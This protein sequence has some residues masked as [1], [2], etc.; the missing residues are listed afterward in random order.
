MRLETVAESFATYRAAV[1]PREASAVQVDE[2]RRAFYAGTYFCLMNLAFNIGDDATSEDEGIAELEKLKAECEAFAAAVGMALPH[3]TP[4]VVEAPV[5]E[6]A[7]YTTPD[8]GEMRPI[9]QELGGRIGADLPAGWGFNLLLFQYGAG[10]SLFY[11]SSAER[12]DVI[13]VM[14]EYIAR[15]TH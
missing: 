15:N 4:P 5:V 8:A 13:A 1:L 14:R 3:A 6:P 12:Q 7:H 2:C 10:G 9:L 11:I